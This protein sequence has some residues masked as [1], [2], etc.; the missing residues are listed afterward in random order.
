MTAA[1]IKI[2][3]RNRHIPLEPCALIAFDKAA[4]ALAEKLLTFDDE[5]LQKFQAVGGERTILLVGTSENLPWTD[6]AIYLGRDAE[7]PAALLPTTVEPNISLE[8]F[9]RALK[10]KFEPLAPFA[11]LPGKI[12]SF[13]AAKTLSRAALEIWLAANR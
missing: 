7:M 9:D 3:W 11:V 12:V 8:L 6:G 4:T 10:A 1:P 5:R 2:G 13:R